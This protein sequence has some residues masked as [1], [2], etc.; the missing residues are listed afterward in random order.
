MSKGLI[1]PAR[2]GIIGFSRTCYYVEEALIRDPT[3]FAAATIADGVDESYIQYLTGVGWSV[4]VPEQE[5]IYGAK[6]FGRD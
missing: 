2:V 3:R 5:A 4:Q 6:P 1:D